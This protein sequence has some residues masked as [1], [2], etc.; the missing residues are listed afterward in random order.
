[1]MG[2]RGKAI[3]FA[4]NKKKEQEIIEKQLEEE[5]KNIDTLLSQN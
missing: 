4:S 2:I 3:A 5:I 1:M